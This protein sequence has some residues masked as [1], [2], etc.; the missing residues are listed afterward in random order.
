MSHYMKFAMGLA[1]LAG[2]QVC[3]L[4]QDGKPWAFSMDVSGSFN[5]NRDG[6]ADNKESQ[7]EMRVRPRADFNTLLGRAEVDA[8][9]SPSFVYRTNRRKIEGAEQKSTEIY[10]DLGV[11][12]DYTASQRLRFAVNESFSLN[13]SP[14][15]MF[16]SRTFREYVTYWVNRFS[17]GG[18]YD[19]MPAR[20]TVSLRADHLKKHYR[21]SGYAAIGDE[22]DIG[23]GGTLKY[24]LQS[25]VTMAGDVTYRD[26]DMGTSDS[27]LSRKLKT[28][29][30]GIG[31]EKVFS[32]WTGRFSLGMDRANEKVTGQTFGFWGTRNS[33]AGD[34]EIILTPTEASR[35][36]L[37]AGHHLARSDISP[38]ATQKRTS[39]TARASH[40]FTK[41]VSAGIDATYAVGKYEGV[42][43]VSAGGS[44]RV[45][46]IGLFGTYVL[47]RNWN[48]N[49][50][51]RRENW[52][53]DDNLR[54][55]HSR[56]VLEI[57]AGAHF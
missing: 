34:V 14:A 9:Y 25:G 50:G 13:D 55:S 56:N 28:L 11:I 33:I 18:S 49:A 29:Y 7:F 42:D 51:Y 23:F 24:I 6:S 31:A 12:M 22:Q 10:H 45:T 57:T 41:L 21:G 30:V 46:S 17:V 52:K 16:T 48:F 35:I 27:G 2:L 26:S 5:D 4:A 3:A 37:Q 54:A 36:G 44:D 19:L 1:V 8:F 47:N 38:F 32:L 53:A 15:E 39:F 20:S 43:L 40:D